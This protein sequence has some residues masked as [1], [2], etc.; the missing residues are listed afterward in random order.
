MKNKSVVLS[1]ILLFLVFVPSF[2][3]AQDLELKKDIILQELQENNSTELEVKNDNFISAKE[4]YETKLN[5]LD[6]YFTLL[7][8]LIGVITIIIVIGGIFQFFTIRR[9]AKSEIKKIN[10]LAQKSKDKFKKEIEDF[11]KLAKE[12]KIKLSEK[13]NQEIKKANAE[14]ERH[15]KELNKIKEKVEKI[16]NFNFRITLA[17]SYFSIT[18]TK[19]SYK[20]I[21]SNLQGAILLTESKIEKYFCY[22]HVG[23]AY[24]RLAEISKEKKDKINNLDMSED[25]YK[26]AFQNYQSPNIKSDIAHAQY[27][28]YML[29]REEILPELLKTINEAI[30]LQESVKGIKQVERLKQRLKDVQKK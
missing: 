9:E 2:V 22:T 3:L 27:K 23:L 25:N 28:L 16:K 5:N 30:I 17:L 8:V 14:F 24:A 7:T 18:K 6:I 11:K 26:N 19:E 29:G 4:F 15:E 12:E 1:V 13:Y 20:F 21:I 10:D